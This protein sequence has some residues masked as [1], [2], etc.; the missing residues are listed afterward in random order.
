MPPWGSVSFFLRAQGGARSFDNYEDGSGN[1][2]RSAFDSQHANVM[3]GYGE[4]ATG[5]QRWTPSFRPVSVKTKVISGFMIQAAS[6]SGCGEVGRSPGLRAAPPSVYV[7][8][9]VRSSSDE[10]GRRSL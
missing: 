6:S 4:A 3:L 7:S 9:G 10:C 2:I 5:Q 8:S 1:E